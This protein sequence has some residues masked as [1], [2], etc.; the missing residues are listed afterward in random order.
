MTDSAPILPPDLSFLTKNQQKAL[1]AIVCQVITQMQSMRPGKIEI[2]FPAGGV[3]TTMPCLDV[4]NLL[5]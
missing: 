1:K 4:K 3:P 5:E 2:N